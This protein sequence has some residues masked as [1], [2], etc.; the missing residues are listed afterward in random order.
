MTAIKTITTAREA[1]AAADEAYT[2][3]KAEF[4]EISKAYFDT[5]GLGPKGALESLVRHYGPRIATWAGLPAA[6]L[7]LS[8]SGF[9][10]KITAALGGLF[11]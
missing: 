6:G 2:K 11:G 1:G 9:I 8:E 4:E 10:G 7:A 3:A 5:R